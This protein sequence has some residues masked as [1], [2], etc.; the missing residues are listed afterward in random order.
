MLAQENEA[1]SSWS[2]VEECVLELC[3]GEGV[4]ELC[5]LSVEG[6]LCC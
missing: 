1:V 2:Y 3:R 5:R 6:Y 4:L